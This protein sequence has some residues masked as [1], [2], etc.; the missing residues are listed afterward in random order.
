MYY[1]FGVL[2]VLL[3]CS[4]ISVLI[5]FESRYRFIVLSLNSDDKFRVM[6]GV[7]VVLNSYL[8]LVVSV[9]LV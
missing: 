2:S 9:V 1:V 6:S 5:M 4:V 3:I 7:N 8:K